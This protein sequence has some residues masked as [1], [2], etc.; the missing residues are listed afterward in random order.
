[1][2]SADKTAGFFLC[3]KTKDGTKLAQLAL[4]A[5]VLACMQWDN[6]STAD[7]VCWTSCVPVFGAGPSGGGVVNDG[8]APRA[9]STIKIIKKGVEISI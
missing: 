2:K 6:I 8:R 7:V 3:L 5:M 4:F 9:E 1:M